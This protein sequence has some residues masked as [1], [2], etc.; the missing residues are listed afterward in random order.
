[1]RTA[2]YTRPPRDKPPAVEIFPGTAVGRV[3]AM[4][5]TEEVVD[6]PTGWVNKHI[7]QYVESGGTKG[8]EWRKGVPALLLTTRGRK[9]GVLRRSALI[10]GTDGERYY[11]VASNGGSPGHPAWYL[12]L[13]AEP[14]VEVQVGPETF[15]ATARTAEGDERAELWSVMTAL[16]PD[17]DNYQKRTERQI[18][19][20]VLER[21]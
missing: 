17:Y 11:V 20:V 19:V 15:T 5:H 9:S 4:A 3:D 1:M 7:R 8:H 16:W 10:Y 2:S 21:A 12:N 6:S 14:T 18:P 13:T